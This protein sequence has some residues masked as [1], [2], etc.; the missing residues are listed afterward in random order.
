MPLNTDLTAS[1]SGILGL[2][3]STTMLILY[4]TGMELRLRARQ[5]LYPPND[6]PSPFTPWSLNFLPDKHTCVVNR[7][8]IPA[9]GGWRQDDQ[10]FK[11]ILGYTGSLRPA[12][13]HK[14]LSH[15][16]T[17]KGTVG[18][19]SNLSDHHLDTNSQEP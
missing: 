16:N 17:V 6:I 18:I 11:F 14:I 5:A 13:R 19:A 3:V 2:Q 1:T 10:E 9:T 8:E 12:E 7:F 4:G 15:N